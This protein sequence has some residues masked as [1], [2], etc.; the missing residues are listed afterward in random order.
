[1]TKGIKKEFMDFYE[2]RHRNVKK[3]IHERKHYL[4][5]TIKD[6]CDKYSL[7]LPSHDREKIH[8]ILKE[9]RKYFYRLM[10]I[11]NAWSTL[12][13][14][15]KKKKDIPNVGAQCDHIKKKH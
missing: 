13:L 9:T 7:Y 2:N 6:I 10:V 3:S 5:N 4:E 15:K 1:M 8:Q 11:E 12:A 14:F